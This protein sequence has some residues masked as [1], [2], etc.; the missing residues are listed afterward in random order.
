M[1]TLFEK[2]DE[3]LDDLIPFILGLSLIHG[4]NARYYYDERIRAR[5]SL[6]VV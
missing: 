1:M 4:K 6:L 3:I 5:T 2:D